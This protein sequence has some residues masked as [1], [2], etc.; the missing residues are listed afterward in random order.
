MQ[1]PEFWESL[2]RIDPVGK[3][4]PD[5]IDVRQSGAMTLPSFPHRR[6]LD[7]PRYS[8]RGTR[9]QIHTLT[10]LPKLGAAVTFQ[11]EDSKI[12]QKK[13]RLKCHRS[14]APQDRMIEPMIDYKT[15]K[16]AKVLFVG[17]NPHPGSYRRGVPFSNNKMFWYLL[18]R[19]GLLPG[20]RERF[21][22]GRIAQDNLRQ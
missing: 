16:S 11:A 10:P 2:P 20:R 17:I 6:R 13:C 5:R 14:P 7:R 12:P 18:N 8:H 21:E 1:T 9:R 19:A 3:P 4:G 15:S 22:N